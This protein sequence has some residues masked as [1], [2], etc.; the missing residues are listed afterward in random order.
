MLLTP[1]FE[2]RN[3][4]VEQVGSN[5][6]AINGVKLRKGEKRKAHHEDIIEVLESSHF[7]KLEFIPPVEPS[8][9][10]EACS[11][12]C[13]GSPKVDKNLYGGSIE[14]FMKDALLE[15]PGS[16]KS[17]EQD[18]LLVFSSSDVESREKV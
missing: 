9:L 1:N 17:L 6:S 16:W 15:Q 7:F 4:I 3:V 10:D 13:G 5:P 18:R 14:Y 12:Q 11:S 8:N 2:Q